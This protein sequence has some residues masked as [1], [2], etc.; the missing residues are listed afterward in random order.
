MEQTA[1]I[2]PL[3]HFFDRL[4]QNG[5]LLG[6]EEYSTF[7]KVLDHR[8]GLNMPAYQ[9][10]VDEL[11]KRSAEMN[12]AEIFPG[13]EL[14][15]LCKLLWLKPGY[16]EQVFEEIFEAS[17]LL[18]FGSSKERPKQE[19]TVDEEENKLK[20]EDAPK[21]DDK[22]G[23]KKQPAQES[24]AESEAVDADIPANQPIPVR[25]AV[26]EYKPKHNLGIE[27]REVEIEKSKFLFTQYYFPVDRRKIQQNLRAFPSFRQADP[28]LEI[29]VDATIK[30]TISKGYFSGFTFKKQRTN[31]IRLLLL[32][33]HLGSM[34]AFEQLAVQLQ[35]EMEQALGIT[36]SA[37]AR[38]LF[39][40][41]FYNSFDKHVYLNRI[42]TKTES[43]DRMLGHLKSASDG[44]I[45]FSDA[46]AARN[47]YNPRRVE[48]N[49]KFLRKLNDRTNKI[50]W[51]NPMPQ[52][53][54]QNTS[55]EVIAKN[56]AM[57]EANEAGI[58]NAVDFLK[59][60]AKIIKLA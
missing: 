18:D 43:A 8:L 60:T 20:K 9:N 55:A 44:I 58:K 59:G 30:K 42:H 7:L 13:R 52:E 2:L 21:P 14:L 12:V 41:Y 26:S 33:D 3:Y 40:F 56:V 46:G 28:S 54:W 27:D 36:K 39:N 24:H 48:A 32:T 45:I 50:A 15:H 16:S 6:I 17:Y 19:T 23:N 34:V 22:T 57:F 37:D 1:S 49:R 38:R 35:R 47:L 51:L 31:A 53:R 5:F 10:L 25:I 11:N 4:R 29:D